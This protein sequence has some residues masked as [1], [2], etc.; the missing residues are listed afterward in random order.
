MVV[1]FNNL[2]CLCNRGVCVYTIKNNTDLTVAII[3]NL[4]KC[5]NGL[6]RKLR[7]TTKHVSLLIFHIK[8]LLS[9]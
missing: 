7:L 1:T 6:Y 3:E 5:G 2:L 9:I 8:H 4:S